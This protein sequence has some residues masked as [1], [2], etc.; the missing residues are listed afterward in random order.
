MIEFVA[1]YASEQKLEFDY[2]LYRE[3]VE[4][5]NLIMRYLESS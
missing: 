2:P 1:P 3:A 4:G 5:A